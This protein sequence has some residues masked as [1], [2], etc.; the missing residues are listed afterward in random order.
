MELSGELML[1]LILCG[2]APSGNE[3]D[4]YC[5]F[6][7]ALSKIEPVFETQVTESNISFAGWCLYSYTI[8][9]YEPCYTCCRVYVGDLTPLVE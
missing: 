7:S 9:G 4:A 2:E 5:F 8:C 1:M 6:V 3:R